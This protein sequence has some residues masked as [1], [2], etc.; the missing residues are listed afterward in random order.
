MTPP[1]GL[2]FYLQD[3]ALVLLYLGTSSCQVL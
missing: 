1:E 2:G 3:G